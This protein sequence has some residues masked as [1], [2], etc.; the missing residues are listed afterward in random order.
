MNNDVDFEGETRLRRQRAHSLP[1]EMWLTIASPSG[2]AQ[3]PLRSSVDVI[4]GRSRECDVSVEDPDVSRRHAS[5][6]ADEGLF[7]T[8]LGSRNGTYVGRQRLPAHQ[9][10]AISP[11][12]VVELGSTT[13]IVRAGDGHSHRSCTNPF[14]DE[15]LEGT[16][17][18]SARAGDTFPSKPSTG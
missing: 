10:T 15:S 7:V 17:H 1:G 11:S 16:C 3:V 6:V 12:D 14:F 4:V 5:I 8:D 2:L 13:I 18:R 9:R